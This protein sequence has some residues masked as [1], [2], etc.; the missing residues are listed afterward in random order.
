MH[1]N[2][3]FKSLIKYYKHN[4][5]SLKELINIIK[6]DKDISLRIIDWFVTN[7]SK[8]NNIFYVVNNENFNVYY[9][10]KTQLKSF[11]KKH[12][13]PFCRRNRIMVDLYDKKME[14]TIG[15]LNFFKWAIENNIMD[16]IRKNYKNIEKDMNFTFNESKKNCKRRELSLSASRGLIKNNQKIILRFE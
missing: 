11:S 7:F 4:D 9:S 3:L 16:Y 6:N 12:F 5:D 15:Q 1:N 10:Y 8:K 14:T 2:L 13:D